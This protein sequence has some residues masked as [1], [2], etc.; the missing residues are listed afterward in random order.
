FLGRLVTVAS[1]LSS[2]DLATPATA[3]TLDPH[4]P[5][6]RPAATIEGSTSFGDA[7][8]S[9]PDS[10]APA[11]ASLAGWNRVSS[12][13]EGPI[14]SDRTRLAVAGSWTRASDDRRDRQRRDD[15]TVASVFANLT[16]TTG[17]GD[18]LQAIG[19]VQHS[20]AP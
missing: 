15:S 1:G 11:I 18:E 5:G 4:A 16:T 14:G 2:L 3:V 12:I 10:V 17:G 13:V 20:G 8:T 19:W 6:A 7:L 9:T